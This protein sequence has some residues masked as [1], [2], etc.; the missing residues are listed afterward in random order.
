M[1]A[2]SSYGA[3]TGSHDPL[4]FPG[5]YL[6]FWHG[7]LIGSLGG[8]LLTLVGLGVWTLKITHEERL[9]AEAQAGCVP[10]WCPHTF[11]TEEAAQEAL[12]D[13]VTADNPKEVP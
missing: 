3:L 11:D 1:G 9:S 2:E 13:L 10:S 4:S 5:K 7:L 6:T 12:R 8:V